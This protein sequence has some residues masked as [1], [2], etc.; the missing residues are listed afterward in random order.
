MHYR[1]A[2]RTE[3]GQCAEPA[4]GRDKICHPTGRGLR[5]SAPGA[6][7]TRRLREGNARAPTPFVR[8]GDLKVILITRLLPWHNRAPAR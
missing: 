3:P 7:H 5:L 4:V 2:I 8:F 6:C 1:F